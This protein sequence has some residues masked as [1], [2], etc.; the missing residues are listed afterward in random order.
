MGRWRKTMDPLHH[1]LGP[2]LGFLASFSFTPRRVKKKAPHG[3]VFSSFLPRCRLSRILH[4]AWPRPG[5]PRT[6]PLRKRLPLPRPAALPCQP[7][8]CASSTKPN[9]RR[10]R[11][12][13][14]SSVQ[15]HRP[16]R[17]R[18]SQERGTS[19][20]SVMTT[21]MR[22]PCRQAVCIAT[23]FDFPSV[24]S[25]KARGNA[26]AAVRTGESGPLEGNET[27]RALRGLASEGG[28]PKD[29]ARQ[30]E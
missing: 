15:Y 30:G 19:T 9:S 21:S 7:A 23:Q 27:D 4:T 8:T 24:A 18:R 25:R 26:V 13:G 10:L 5:R 12:A 22:A 14:M 3:R 28:A 16:L 1:S 17:E 6:R 20:S 11:S 2:A 29:A